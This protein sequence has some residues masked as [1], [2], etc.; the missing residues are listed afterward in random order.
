MSG[1][2]NFHHRRTKQITERRRIHPCSRSLPDQARR[3]W[4]RNRISG[5]A[6]VRVQA[7][8]PMFYKM[9]MSEGPRGQRGAPVEQTAP[10]IHRTITKRGTCLTGTRGRRLYTAPKV[11]TSLTVCF[12]CTVGRVHQVGVKTRARERER[13]KKEK[14]ERERERVHNWRWEKVRAEGG[15]GTLLRP[16]AA[17]EIHKHWPLAR[18][19]PSSPSRP[20]HPHPRYHPPTRPP[21]APQLAESSHGAKYNTAKCCS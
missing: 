18:S 11:N 15:S 14:K 19:S 13:G 5:L 4:P 7:S 8:A 9:N 16:C 1:G 17:A 2:Y 3:R 12:S 20:P 6:G 10:Q 21:N